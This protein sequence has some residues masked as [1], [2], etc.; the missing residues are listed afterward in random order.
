MSVA[1]WSSEKQ[2]LDYVKLTH[3]EKANELKTYW[4]KKYLQSV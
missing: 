1:G 2:M 3:T 4:E